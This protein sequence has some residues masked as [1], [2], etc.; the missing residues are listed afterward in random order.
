V[1]KSKGRASRRLPRRGALPE[2]STSGALNRLPREGAVSLK[3]LLRHSRSLG[4]AANAIQAQT[5][6][7]GRRPPRS[8][9][10]VGASTLRKLAQSCG[11]VWVALAERSAHPLER[12]VA[13]ARL[14]ATQLTASARCWVDLHS[15]EGARDRVTCGESVGREMLRAR[16]RSSRLNAARRHEWHA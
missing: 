10:L 5:E 12:A 4:G 7:A 13:A 9:A 6:R 8:G 1:N 14:T 15:R 11:D 16:G 3:S 2:A